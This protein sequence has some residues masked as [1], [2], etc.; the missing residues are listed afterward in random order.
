MACKSTFSELLKKYDGQRELKALEAVV[1]KRA[2]AQKDAK[3][4]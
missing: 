2:E 1:E 4:K 3:Q